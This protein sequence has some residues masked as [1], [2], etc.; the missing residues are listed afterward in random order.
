MAI[1]HFSNCVARIRSRIANLIH[2]RRAG[3]PESQFEIN[4]LVS[5][6]PNVPLTEP[7]GA[8]FSTYYCPG[9]YRRLVGLGRLAPGRSAEHFSASV[10]LSMVGVLPG[11]RSAARS[12]RTQ[13]ERLPPKRSTAAR[14]TLQVWRGTSASSARPII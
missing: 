11:K 14:K 9:F 13:L 7:P 6:G 8:M 10:A 4:I 5:D 3:A 2:L 12:A 1:A